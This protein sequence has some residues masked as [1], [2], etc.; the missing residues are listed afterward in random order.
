MSV[1]FFFDILLNFRTAFVVPGGVEVLVDTPH[2]IASRY[3]R[4][5]FLVDVVSTIPWDLL[6]ASGPLHATRL[7]QATKIAKLS[8]FLRALKL[9]RILR[10]LRVC[11]SALT[12]RP[13]HVCMSY[14]DALHSVDA[15][16]TPLHCRDDIC[17]CLYCS[18]SSPFT[19]TG[20]APQARAL[21]K[22]LEDTIGLMVVRICH[23][24][25]VIVFILHIFACAFHFVALLTEPADADTW[26][27][28]SGLVDANSLMDRYVTSL[29]W[30]MSTMAT[31]GYGDVTPIQVRARDTCLQLCVL[32]AVSRPRSVSWSPCVKLQLPARHSLRTASG[33][34]SGDQR[35]CPIKTRRQLRRGAECV[36]TVQIPEKV[37][38]MLGMLVGVTVFAYTM[39]TLSDL[40]GMRNTRDMRLAERQRHLDTFCRAYRLPPALSHKLK[41]YYDYVSACELSREDFA[42]MGGLS[43]T[44]RQQVQHGFGRSP[45][46]RAGVA[47]DAMIDA[48]S[49]LLRRMSH[50]PSLA[51]LGRAAYH[52]LHAQT[53]AAP[54]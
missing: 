36:H 54:R 41:R 27:E 43:A 44:L 37:I 5:F 14:S 31:V 1:T 29:Y 4:G 51:R 35:R 28:A 32:A 11:P 10:L 47:Q 9:I 13:E 3:C 50:A 30:A 40:F 46:S 52:N 7:L 6:L 12:W 8:R 24:V 38:A 42:L 25:F 26:V 17:G 49:G 45:A 33:L 48:N 20:A 18:M 16:E 39:S 53:G 21:R 2:K 22:V 15:D 34:R 23:L 19:V